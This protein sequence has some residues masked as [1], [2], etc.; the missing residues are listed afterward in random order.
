MELQEAVHWTEMLRA[1]KT[2]V[3]FVKHNNRSSIL[4]FFSNLF[5]RDTVQRPVVIPHLRYKT[6]TNQIT[7]G[8]K[9]L[10]RLGH[11]FVETEI[12]TEL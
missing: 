4:R 5:S 1:S 6:T 10:P 12:G 9:A 2:D 7:P 3:P 11:D 8:I